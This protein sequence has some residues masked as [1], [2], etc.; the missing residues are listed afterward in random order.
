MQSEYNQDQ[1]LEHIY[2]EVQQQFMGIA[3][4]AHGWEH[5]YRVYRGALYLAK[6]EGADQH[7]VGMAALLH[8][9]G[10]T[11]VQEGEHHADRSVAL[12]EAVLQRYQVPAEQQQAILHAILAHSFSRGVEPRTVEACV[13]RDADRLDAL[14][15]IGIMRWAIVGSRR[16]TPET[17]AYHP[18]DP[19]AEEHE[20]QDHLYMLDHFYTKL[21]NLVDTMTTATGRRLAEQRTAFMHAY[22]RAFKAEVDLLQF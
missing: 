8:D 9:G 12:A 20:P 18:T 16:S 7:I 6:H 4:L 1:V 21:L 17:L 13:V 15:A 2:A 11:A 19:L 10:H 3:D 14:G 5:V 22:L